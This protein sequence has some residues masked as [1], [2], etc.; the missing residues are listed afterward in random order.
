MKSIEAMYNM[1]VNELEEVMSE[2]HKLMALAEELVEV[3]NAHKGN[4]FVTTGALAI[5]LINIAQ[6]SGIPKDAFIKA[7]AQ[8]VERMYAQDG[9]T[10]Q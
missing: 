4:A 6:Q 1:D 5:S 8:Q 7:F 3:C 9:E 10:M 2:E